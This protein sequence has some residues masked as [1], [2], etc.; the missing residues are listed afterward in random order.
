[1]CLLAP[2]YLQQDSESLLVCKTRTALVNEVSRTVVSMSE[3]GEIPEVTAQPII[4]G[5]PEFLEFILER[6]KEPN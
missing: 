1:M 2:A 4:G 5:N 6:T 3:Q